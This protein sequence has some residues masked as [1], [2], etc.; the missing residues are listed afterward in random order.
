MG[1]IAVFIVLNL[2]SSFSFSN[3]SAEYRTKY[4]KECIEK[5][6]IASCLEA[7]RSTMFSP[8]ILN[9][10]IYYSHACKLGAPHA[11]ELALVPEVKIKKSAAD[12]L[13]CDTKNDATSC[14]DYGSFMDYAHPESPDGDNYRLKACNLKES[15]AC[16]ILGYDY[17]QRENSIKPTNF[18]LR[19]AL[20]TTKSDAAGLLRLKFAN[21]TILI[22]A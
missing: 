10:K 4:Q 21:V 17:E 18:T 2:I 8:D 13:K 15:A 5:N 19:L 9:A 12:K 6:N 11:C 1:P 22:R 3:T 16:Y 14:K 20:S 7:G